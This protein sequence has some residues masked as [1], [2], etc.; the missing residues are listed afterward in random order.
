MLCLE[1]NKAATTHAPRDCS[2][3]DTPSSS[4]FRASELRAESRPQ[5]VHP[6]LVAPGT[7]AEPS[8]ERGRAI[9]AVESLVKEPAASRHTAAR[10][11]LD[12]DRV[13]QRAVDA[14][15][16]ELLHHG[17]T[18]PKRALA[19][20]EIIHEDRVVVCAN[21]EP[22]D[23]SLSSRGMHLGLA[24]ESLAVD[25]GLQPPEERTLPPRRDV[26]ARAGYRREQCRDCHGE[27]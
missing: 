27:T 21:V 20:A 2:F 5:E 24:H 26:A 13:A 22:V 6:G 8:A 15:E 17:R 10:P 23:T 3:M 4:S 25:T 9:G 16:V 11:N 1:I 19:R 7:H 18:L 14:V 12:H